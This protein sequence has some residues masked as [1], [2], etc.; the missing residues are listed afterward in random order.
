MSAQR[1]RLV[2]LVR[3]GVE[4]FLG[5][6]VQ[7]KYEPIGDRVAYVNELRKKLVEEA[8]EYAMDPSVE[9]AADVFETLRTLA[10]VDLAVGMS[11]IEDA[12]WRKR[13]E[14]GGFD[15]GI[16]M[17]LNVAGEHADPQAEPTTTRGS[18]GEVL[19]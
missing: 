6:E 11:H 4:K 13:Q 9:E 14:R 12:A 18:L 17:Y 16:G 8:V 5:G 19:R 7:V 1:R 15:Q 10:R 2:K 3:D